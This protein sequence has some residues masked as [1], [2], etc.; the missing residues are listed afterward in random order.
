MIL[1]LS[2]VSFLGRERGEKRA[3]LAALC[4]ISYF[5]LLLPRARL[6]GLLQRA[7][8]LSERK[9][10][11]MAEEDLA[12]PQLSWALSRASQLVPGATCLVQALAGKVVFSLAGYESTVKIGVRKDEDEGIWAHAWLISGRE[13]VVG[14]RPDLDAYV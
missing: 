11:R 8:H 13:V 10:G 1:P 5:R 3:F 9:L 4:W 12:A 2:L 7:D 6:A 14:A